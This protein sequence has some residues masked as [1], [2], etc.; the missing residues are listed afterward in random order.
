MARRLTILP[1]N[2]AAFCAMERVGEEGD[3]SSPDGGAGLDA[4]AD[5]RALD[6]RSKRAIG[7]LCPCRSDDRGYDRVLG[8][9]RQ[10]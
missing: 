7:R 5:T 10:G 1:R 4:Q 9:L 6:A 3:L 2:G 8:Q